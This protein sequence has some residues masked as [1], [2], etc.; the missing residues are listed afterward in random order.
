[1]SD[2]RDLYQSI[3]DQII[4]E[5]EAGVF[6]WG[7]PWKSAKVSGSALAAQGFALPYNATTERR[8]SGVNT[9]LLWCERD[10][11]GYALPAWLTFKQAVTAGGRVRK[12]ET[13][14]VAVFADKFIPKTEAAKARAEGREAVPVYYLKAFTLFNVEQC[15]GL[16]EAM[17]SL[18]PPTEP[19]PLPERLDAIAQT[20]GVNVRL[21]GNRA[22]YT[23]ALD[24]V[25]MPHVAQFP[26]RLD[27]DRTLLHELTHA[28]GHPTRL[29][30]DLS[31]SF[32][33]ANYA[34]EELC[35][36]LGAAMA[37]AAMG[38]EPTVQHASYL[39][40]W[41]KVLKE[42]NRAIFRAAAQATKAA[43]MLLDAEAKGREAAAQA[44]AELAA[45]RAS[46]YAEAKAA[47]RD[48][49]EEY[50][51]GSASASVMRDYKAGRVKTI[52][53]SR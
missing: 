49:L 33:S 38:I 52:G 44:A 19:A 17:T 15:D 9:L 36:E 8:Y 18:A 30:R 14:T 47:A 23:T 43:D 46:E 3:T 5:L 6:P 26:D 31:G 53:A 42:D 45:T 21:G 50:W 48:S 29:A 4:A 22:F 20:L 16:P 27:F 51:A 2:R 11:N 37:A 35:A 10:R 24:S 12:G 41:L 25:T 34:R 39:E 32:G 28:T 1:M 7:R 40:S 13:G